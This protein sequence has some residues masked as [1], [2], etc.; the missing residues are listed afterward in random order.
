M[1]Y[2]TNIEKKTLDNT[3]HRNVLYTNVDMQLVVM[4]LLPN[5]EIGKEKHDGS[6]FI[7]VEKGSGIAI[8]KDKRYI[9]KDGSALII[10]ANT[11]HTIIAGDNGMKLYSI[12]SPPQHENGT[13]EKHKKE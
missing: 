2:K 12:Y 7:K 5:E 6:Q 11:Y 9:L 3:Y 10:N 8:V 13:K 1:S 4:D